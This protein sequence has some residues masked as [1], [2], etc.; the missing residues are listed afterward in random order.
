LRKNEKVGK[1][2]GCLAIGKHCPLTNWT[3][4]EANI[5]LNLF[6]SKNPFVAVSAV[7]EDCLLRIFLFY[8]HFVDS[9]FTLL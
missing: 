9:F 1:A 2:G 5:F 8:Q 3:A 6:P 7:S 4:S